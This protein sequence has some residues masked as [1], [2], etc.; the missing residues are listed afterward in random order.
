MTLPGIDV[1]AIGQGSAFNWEAYRGKIAFA[2]IKATQGT[3][4]QD[5]DFSLNM[6][7]CAKI[8][9]MRMPYHFLEPQLSGAEQA[10]WFLGYAKPQP[11]ELVMLDNETCTNAA[12]AALAP[13]LVADCAAE[14]GDKVRAALGAWPVL[15]TTPWMAENGYCAGLGQQPLFI[16]GN[17]K[18][19]PPV[20]GPWRLIS[21]AQI[22][23]RGVD[24]DVFFGTAADLMRLTVLHTEVKSAPE[25]LKSYRLAWEGQNKAPEIFDL[26]STDGGKT[27]HQ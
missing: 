20:I 26:V 18:G 3:G 25:P 7:G 11:G 10:A 16:A 12:G 8:G 6:N 22:G 1:S 4:F 17:P 5:P 15:Y 14:F 21:F 2:G 23:T 9:A 27:W 24:T 19:L 13:G